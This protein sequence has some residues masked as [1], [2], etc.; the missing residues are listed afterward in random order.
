MCGGAQRVKSKILQVRHLPSPIVCPK[1]TVGSNWG[2][3]FRCRLSVVQREE[4]M[5][6]EYK[7]Q[8]IS[9]RQGEASGVS[10]LVRQLSTDSLST[11]H[12]QTR[13]AVAEYT[14]VDVV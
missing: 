8:T 2:Q 5:S 1:V 9:I 10:Q 11:R 3:T 7:L 14:V 12:D 6:Y 13:P 4:W